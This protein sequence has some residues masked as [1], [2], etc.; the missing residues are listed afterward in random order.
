MTLILCGKDGLN[1][2]V[3][4]LFFQSHHILSLDLVR[5]SESKRPKHRVLAS[6][7]PLP[8]QFMAQPSMHEVT[9]SG[10]T[11]CVFGIPVA[12]VTLHVIQ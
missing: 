3:Q 2:H 8:E 11:F 5:L 7:L 4:Q 12:G 10:G 6:L 9:C 1:G